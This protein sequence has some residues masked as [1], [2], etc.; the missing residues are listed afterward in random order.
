MS[1]LPSFSGMSSVG[2]SSLLTKWGGGDEGRGY[3]SPLRSG[4]TSALDSM[5]YR[6]FFERGFVR[7]T[8]VGGMLLGTA[9]S[10]DNE[11]INR[12]HCTR[13][14]GARCGCFFPSTHTYTHKNS[15]SLCCS[16]SLS[17]L[18]SLSLFAALNSL[19]LSLSLSLSISSFLSFFLSPFQSFLV[20]CPSERFEHALDLEVKKI[21]LVATYLCAPITYRYRD[22]EVTN[23]ELQVALMST[24]F[25]VVRKACI[26]S[27]DMSPLCSFTQGALC[28]WL[29]ALQHK[30]VAFDPIFNKLR[31]LWPETISYSP[32]ADEVY[33][34]LCG[35][36]V[37]QLFRLVELA[38]S[39]VS[40]AGSEGVSLPPPPF[41]LD[42]YSGWCSLLFQFPP[43]LILSWSHCHAFM[44]KYL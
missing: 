39:C 19:S 14:L 26:L 7:F 6:V 20:G 16:L 2:Q 23:M 31:S 44:S 38:S 22:E 18:P 10:C 41:G 42:A 25:F 30:T 32:V 35:S 1:A 11:F 4:L 29:Q 12:V 33:Q 3:A 8:D 36:A 13:L 28:V 43:L 34:E 17:L 21:M 9:S 40:I 27:C 5:E 24:L 15:L 37:D